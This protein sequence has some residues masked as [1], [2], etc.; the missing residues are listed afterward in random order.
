MDR[1]FAKTFLSVF[2]ALFLPGLGGALAQE[3]AEAE[4]REAA[5]AKSHESVEAVPIDSNVAA[6]SDSPLEY[7]F[8]PKVAAKFGDPVFIPIAIRNQTAEI[9]RAPAFRYHYAGGYRIHSDGLEK[10]AL[11]KRGFT[12]LS[13][14]HYLPPYHIETTVLLINIW[15]PDLALRIKENG[16]ATIEFYEF[17][18]APKDDLSGLVMVTRGK[19]EL[20]I[21]SSS[22]SPAIE[23]RLLD[24]ARDLTSDA[25]S[26]WGLSPGNPDTSVFESGQSPLSWLV[27]KAPKFEEWDNPESQL[28]Q[29]ARSLVSPDTKL[30]RM[31]RCRVIMVQ[32]CGLIPAK[33]KTAMDLLND[34]FELVD[35]CEEYEKQYHLVALKA[36]NTIILSNPRVREPGITQQ[37]IYA[38]ARKRFPLYAMYFNRDAN[39]EAGEY[40]VITGPVPLMPKK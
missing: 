25:D 22:F 12:P 38:A 15:S 11:F 40:S 1:Y 19:T 36:F 17:E 39:E 31:M 14:A 28:F 23:K 21:T 20:T 32:L 33:D 29:D 27:R 35:Q 2:L 26:E 30:D 4:S 8:P 24:I 37:Q 13:M 7:L 3:S 6:E 18:E 9:V 16:K 34:Y 5:G 10:S